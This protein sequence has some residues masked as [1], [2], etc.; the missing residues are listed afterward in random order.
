[1]EDNLRFTSGG[2]YMIGPAVGKSII[3]CYLV[4]SMTR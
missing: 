4:V 3:F 2:K 1:M